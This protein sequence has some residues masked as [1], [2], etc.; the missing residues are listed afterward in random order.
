MTTFLFLLTGL[1]VV[2]G[3]VVALVRRRNRD[4]FDGGSVREAAEIAY[5]DLDRAGSPLAAVAR[6]FGRGA[7]AWFEENLCKIIPGARNSDA[8]ITR[9][10]LRDYLRW[11]RTV[12]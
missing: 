12:Q 8:R 7:I 2:L 5:D 11:A 3:M 1:V 9:K 4:S 6:G 10:Q